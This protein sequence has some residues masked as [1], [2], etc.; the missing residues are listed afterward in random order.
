MKTIAAILLA[1]GLIAQASSA[2]AVGL[3]LPGNT[4]GAKAYESLKNESESLWQKISQSTHT[5]GGRAGGKTLDLSKYQDCLPEILV[6]KGGSGYVVLPF[7]EYHGLLENGVLDL[8]KT[9]LRNR[10]GQVPDISHW[11]GYKCKSV[12]EPASVL[13]GLLA[14]AMGVVGYRRMR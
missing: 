1:V 8:A 9:S 7:G 13:A 3:W 2:H 14:L 10:G 11:R 12:P 5:I 6:I 4:E